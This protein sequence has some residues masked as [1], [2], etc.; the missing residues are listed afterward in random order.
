M[1]SDHPLNETTVLEYFTHSR[2]YDKTCNNEKVKAGG[3]ARLEKMTGIEY[4][5]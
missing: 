1:Y 2:F 5:A 4:V 3:T